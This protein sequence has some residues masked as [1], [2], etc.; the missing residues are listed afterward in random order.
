MSQPLPEPSSA[1][2]D[3]RELLLRYLDFYRS[4]VVRKVD[5]LTERQCRTSLLPSGWSPLELLHHL[6]HMERRWLIWGFAGE[7]VTDPWGDQGAD[8]RWSVDATIASGELVQ[9]LHDGGRRT[10]A[11]VE[12]ARLDDLARPGGR[13]E[14]DPPTLVWILFHVLQEYARHAGHLD[15]AREL[16]DGLVGEDPSPR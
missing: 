2:A 7:D 16:V 9:A 15:V 3:P 14:Q 13:F 1:I 12:A 6:V 8:E 11:I 5:G 4:E 10:R